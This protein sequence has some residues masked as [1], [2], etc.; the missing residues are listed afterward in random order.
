[1]KVAIIGYGISG[2]SILKELIDSD[3]HNHIDEIHVF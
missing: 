1:M 2:A 3:S